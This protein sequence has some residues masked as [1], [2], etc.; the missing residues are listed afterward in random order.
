MDSTFSGGIGWN[1]ALSFAAIFTI[2]STAS[3]RCL[4]CFC[5]SR[6]LYAF[7]GA[8]E[9]FAS[10]AGGDQLAQGCGD[11]AHGLKASHGG[12]MLGISEGSHTTGCLGGVEAQLK[13]PPPLTAPH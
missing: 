5:G 12:C 13:P 3:L 2:P 6:C 11:H 4:I 8:H 7:N 9:R 1:F 10:Q